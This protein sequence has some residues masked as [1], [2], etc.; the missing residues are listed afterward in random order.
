MRVDPKSKRGFTD[1]WLKGETTMT[2][3][4]S[5]AAALLSDPK[6]TIVCVKVY[7]DARGYFMPVTFEKGWSLDGT[8]K[9]K[10]GEEA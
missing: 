10:E 7:N 5:E 3:A 4:P 6:D 8:H 2:D 9:L 1:E